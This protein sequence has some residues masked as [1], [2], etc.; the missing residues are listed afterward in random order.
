MTGV[1]SLGVGGYDA[2]PS[3]NAVG[4]VEVSK[5]SYDAGS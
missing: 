3:G 2:P 5:N 4:P 1:D